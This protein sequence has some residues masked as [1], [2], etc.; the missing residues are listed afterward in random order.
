M[1]ELINDIRMISQYYSD[2]S[3]VKQTLRQIQDSESCISDT[4]ITLLTSLKE[5]S[6]QIREKAQARYSRFNVGAALLTGNGTIIG[7]V[8]VESSSYGLT[9]CAERSALVSALSQGF[10]EFV[11]IAVSAETKQPISPCGACRQLLLDYAPTAHCIMLNSDGSLEQ[12]QDI[13]SLLPYGF[14]GA[15]LG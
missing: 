6:I 15:V 8:N 1:G 11:A 7:G 2:I 4:T 9:I 12:W 13:G 5:F 10:T 14:D 3:Q